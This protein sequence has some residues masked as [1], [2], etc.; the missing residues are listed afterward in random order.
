MRVPGSNLMNMASRVISQTTVSY[1]AYTGRATN[2]NYVDVA[3]YAPA[4]NIK[5]SL[6][7]VARDMYEKMNL[8]FTKTYYNFF[9]SK[10]LLDLQRD[11]SGDIFIFAGNEYKVESITPWFEIDGWVQALAI[12]VNPQ[13]G[14]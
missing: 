9:C 8:D 2:E 1:R 5:G 10:A 7:P 6:Q 13:A 11:V 4:V 3:T 14:S 12:R